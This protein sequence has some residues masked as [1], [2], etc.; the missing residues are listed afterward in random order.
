MGVSDGGG[1]A[2]GFDITDRA[3]ATMHL[4]GSAW[5]VVLHLAEENG[6]QPEGTVAPPGV[7]PE[8]W[9][10]QYDSND[11]QSMS[12][13]DAAAFAS[14]LERAALDP[15]RS[16]TIHQVADRISAMVREATKSDYQIETSASYWPAIDDLIRLCRRGPVVLE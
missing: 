1:V 5:T 16:R 7:A 11:G 12:A 10:G 6:W 14:A 3:G 13:R 8:S 15:N 9:D 4:T 2:V